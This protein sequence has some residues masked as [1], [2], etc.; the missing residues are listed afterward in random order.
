LI[1]SAATSESAYYFV[2]Y[3]TMALSGQGA[4]SQVEPA[5]QEQF[6]ASIAEAAVRSADQTGVPASV[7]LRRDGR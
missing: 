2:R 7:S 3:P 4:I 5:P 6:I 1:L